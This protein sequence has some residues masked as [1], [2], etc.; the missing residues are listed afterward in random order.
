MGDLQITIICLK[1]H[2]LIMLSISAVNNVLQSLSMQ[3]N[4]LF[5]F[6]F[7]SFTGIHWPNSVSASLPFSY[8]RE[9]SLSYLCKPISSWVVQYNLWFLNKNI[10]LYVRQDKINNAIKNLDAPVYCGVSSATECLRKILWG[11]GSDLKSNFLWK[12]W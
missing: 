4:F 7:K 12:K 2:R 3:P 11:L 1:Y 8:E 6:C 10:I 9:M 5:L